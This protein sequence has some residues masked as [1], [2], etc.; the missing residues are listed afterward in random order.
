M[1]KLEKC[2][3]FILTV[4]VFFATNCRYVVYLD[5]YY[6]REVT[7]VTYF[8]VSVFLLIVYLTTFLSIFRN[9]S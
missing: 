2:V 5:P 9:K 3:N 8:I 7:L 6:V 1:N 4:P